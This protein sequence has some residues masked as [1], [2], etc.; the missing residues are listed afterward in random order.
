MSRPLISRPYL[1]MMEF[2]SYL[3]LERGVETAKHPNRLAISNMEASFQL[4][5]LYMWKLLAW[6]AFIAAV[7]L[8]INFRSLNEIS[9]V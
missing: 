5:W 7:A 6:Y 4:E 1:N 3:A 2:R 8:Y 9:G